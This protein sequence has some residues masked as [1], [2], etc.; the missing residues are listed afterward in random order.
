MNLR[1]LA[2]ELRSFEGVTRKY[3]V[4]TVVEGL[5]EPL[6]VTFEGEVIADVGEDAAAVKVGDD[7]LLIAADGIWGKLID[8]DPWWAG[9]CAVLVNVND[10]LAMGGRPV[11]LVNVLST[12]DVDVCR[13]ILEGMREGAW[14]FSTPVLG[15]HT[16]PDTPY[17]AV[18]AAIVGITNEE[19]LVL[20]ST[21]EEGD[22]IVFVIDLNGRPYPEYPLNWDTTTMKDPDYLRRQ[23]EAVA[24]ASR[25]VKA[26]KDV[27]NPGLVGTLAM[28]LE[29]SG[30]LGAE[31]WLDNIPKPEDVDMATWLKMYPG[32][33]FVYAVD[34]DRDV[35]A[36]KHVLS[37]AG[38]EVSV[39]GEV[40][41]DGVVKVTEGDE[42]ARVFDFREDRILGVSP[43]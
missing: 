38:L 22:L 9:Y 40:T 8:R 2:R 41:E 39:I 11:G 42:S 35:R 24:E 43:R 15:G 12:S 19:H 7:I 32:M 26:G 18:D 27:S 5:L 10:V 31:V 23:M 20:S 33:G 25:L 17:T 6:D 1:E 34:S 30:C 21:A 37:D 29:A 13:E 14:K 36:I 28:M 3:P 4:K 16:H